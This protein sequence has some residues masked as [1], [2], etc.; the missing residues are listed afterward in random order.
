METNYKPGNLTCT[1]VRDL[2]S[3]VLDARRGEIPHPDGTALAESGLWPAIELHLAACESCREE[4]FVLEEIGAAYAEFSVSEQPAQHFADYG[5][6]VRARLHQN[7]AAEG[8]TRFGTFYRR[9]RGWLALGLSGLAAASVA[10]AIARSLDVRQASEQPLAQNEFR[11]V[12]LPAATGGELTLRRSERNSPPRIHV[13]LP[14]K[15]GVQTVSLENP[16]EPNSIQKLRQQEGRL[17]YLYFPVALLGLSLKTTRGQDHPAGADPV[18]LKVDRVAPG[19]P[20]AAMDLRQ[21][22]CIV[23][24]N[25][26]AV[27]DGGTEE[28]LKF[29]SNISEFGPGKEVSIDVVRPVGSQFLYMKR[30][31]GV[32]GQYEVAP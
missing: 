11:P 29:L 4:L 24:L 18:G 30:K 23:T 8:A 25:D 31:Y 22:D 20:A 10:I 14:T 12:A 2:L 5:P 1:E 13:G 3:D 6:R 9:R 27:R 32:L 28:A 17:G 16:F 19:S 15:D 26:M 21:G 7:G